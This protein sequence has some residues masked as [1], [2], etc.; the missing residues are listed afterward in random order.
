MPNADASLRN[1]KRTGGADRLSRR[2]LL[3]A[4]LAAALGL[5][6]VLVTADLFALSHPYKAFRE[7]RLGMSQAEAM[8]SLDRWKVSCDTPINT[9]SRRCE[10]HDSWRTYRVGINVPSSMV[11]RKEYEYRPQIFHH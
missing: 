11:V 6:F 2:S 4:A 7:I 1:A 5:P 8:R 9:D 10:F 3:V